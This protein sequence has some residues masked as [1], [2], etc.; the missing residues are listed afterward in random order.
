MGVP[1][2]STGHLGCKLPHN[3]MHDVTLPMGS[4]SRLVEFSQLMAT[5]ISNVQARDTCGTLP[6][7]RERWDAS[8]PTSRRV[9][10]RNRYSPPCAR[11]CADTSSRC[12]ELLR[13]DAEANVLVKL[14]GTHGGR[15]PVPD[16]TSMASGT[17]LSRARYG[18]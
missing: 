9:M 13:F 7:G 11:G 1:S 8:P 10:N 12:S 18:D 5:A 3:N 4:E 16:G 15:S 6:N 14:F 2:Q 17:P